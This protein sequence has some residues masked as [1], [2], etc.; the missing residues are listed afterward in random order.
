MS[1]RSP[2]NWFRTFIS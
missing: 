2:W 1:Q